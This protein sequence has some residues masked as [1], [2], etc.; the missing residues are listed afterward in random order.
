[1]GSDTVCRICLEFNVKMYS[2]RFYPLETYYEDIVEVNPECSPDL[3]QCVCYLCAALLK[4]YSRFKS[5]C[6][7]AQSLFYKILKSGK[8]VNIESVKSLDKHYLKKS[9][10][11]YTE[12]D[13]TPTDLFHN[14]SPT[15]YLDIPAD[16]NIII[17][18]E[19]SLEINETNS[20]DYCNIEYLSDEDY[21]DLQSQL[22]SKELSLVHLQ[23]EINTNS[24]LS[25]NNIKIEAALTREFEFPDSIDDISSSPSEKIE[26]KQPKRISKSKIS[27]TDSEYPMEKIRR[28]TVEVSEDEINLNE[29]CT[30]QILSKEKQLE[31]IM[32]RK[33]SKNYKNS[34][35]KCQLCYKGFLNNDAWNH[36]LSKHSSSAGSLQCPV[37]KLRFKTRQNLYRHGIN[38]E[39]KYICKRCNHVATT[40]NQAKMHQRWHRG[41]TY[42]CHLCGEVSTKYTSHLSHV[43]IKHP[44]QFVCGACGSSF[45]SR[46]G[47][48]MHRAVMHKHRPEAAEGGPYCAECDLRFASRAAYSKH[49]LTSV[50]HV[51]DVNNKCRI[52]DGS[53]ESSQALQ[54][55]VAQCRRGLPE[56]PAPRPRGD[57]RAPA[58][59]QSWPI[60]CEQCPEQ[61]GSARDYWNHF[62]RAHPDQP[63][64][65]Q[66]NHVCD[67]CGRGFRRKS[68]LV[69]HKWSHSDEPKFKCETCG[70]AF[71]HPNG[72]YFHRRWH[73]DL[74]PFSCPV[75]PKAFLDKFGL[76]RHL[77][78]HTGEKP[79]RCQLCDRAFSQSNSLKGHIQSVHLKKPYPK[80]ARRRRPHPDPRAPASSPAAPLAA[81][82][83]KRLNR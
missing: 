82:N 72:L 69:Y 76:E 22:D 5:K 49:L 81:T 35:H 55:H 32:K 13:V 2:L 78:C 74:R 30:I 58:P 8:K 28:T 25:E 67:V 50:R 75:C 59:D 6:L 45:V 37:C 24:N 18:N 48:A 23:E 15:E 12:T 77:R 73:T 39:R 14:D 17:E 41:I 53:F 60:I 79:Y 66:S 34:P 42:T 9:L 63:Y 68:M 83:K 19:D 3:P 10:T 4:K 46:L 80:R 1:M 47:L 40:A 44:S 21:S 64:P 61:V 11:I 27:K 52:C 31:E 57:R 26:V 62:R 20:E 16:D 43:R 71:Q 54:D 36:H 51:D 7:V 70:K 56:R 29:C 65:A 38:H 33:Y